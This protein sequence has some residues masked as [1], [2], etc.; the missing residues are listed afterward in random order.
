MHN[1]LTAILRIYIPHYFAYLYYIQHI[2]N[3]VLS[4]FHAVTVTKVL[5]SSKICIKKCA[6]LSSGGLQNL[7]SNS[8]LHTC[9]SVNIFISIS[10]ATCWHDITFNSKTKMTLWGWGSYLISCFILII[11][12]VVPRYYLR[13]TIQ[14]SPSLQNNSLYYGP[15]CFCV[16]LKKKGKKRK[17]KEK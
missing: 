4:K 11:Q 17:K 8:S 12:C 5:N 10:E 6:T 15:L 13:N 9:N 2:K 16:L 3:W 14:M 1:F 7:R